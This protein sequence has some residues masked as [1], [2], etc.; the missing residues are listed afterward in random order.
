M[1]I[2]S[3]TELEDGTLLAV[4]ADDDGNVIGTNLYTPESYPRPQL[5][6]EEET[7]GVFRRAWR[8]LVG[9]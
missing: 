6:M 8:W 2:Q 9:E 5:S 1:N 7:P 3:I 4:I